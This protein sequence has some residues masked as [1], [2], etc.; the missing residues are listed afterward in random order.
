MSTNAMQDAKQRV[1]A[2]YPYA[3][4]HRS[5]IGGVS[6]PFEIHSNDDASELL[7]CSVESR[8]AAWEDA[9]MRLGLHNPSEPVPPQDDRAKDA[10][11]SFA[12]SRHLSLETCKDAWGRDQYAASHVEAMWYG[13]QYAFRDGYQ[14]S[15]IAASSAIT[16]RVQAAVAKAVE[17]ALAAAL[18]EFGGKP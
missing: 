13:F 10:F 8:K 15:T 12:K 6:H 18:D 3:V 14:V 4:V 17:E 1:L 2:K 7:G 5:F 16:A 9:A 11:E